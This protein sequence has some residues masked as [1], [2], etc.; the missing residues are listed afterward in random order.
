MNQNFNPVALNQ[1][2]ALGD[3]VEK[4]GDIGYTGYKYDA[5]LALSYM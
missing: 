2:W 3:E 1:V 4:E 5:D